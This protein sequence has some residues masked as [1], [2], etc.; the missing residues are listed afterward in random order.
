MEPDWDGLFFVLTLFHKIVTLHLH[1]G[2]VFFFLVLIFDALIPLCFSCSKP[3]LMDLPPGRTPEDAEV[4]AWRPGMTFSD[5][6]EA[7]F[8]VYYGKKWIDEI[9]TLYLK[10]FYFNS[11]ELRN[12]ILQDEIMES[13]SNLNS[14]GRFFFFF[15]FMIFAQTKLY[16]CDYYL[17]YGHSQINLSTFPSSFTLISVSDDLWRRHCCP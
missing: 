9:E 15:F 7:T 17:V 4:G 11:I 8:D 12:V 3:V 14:S 6:G 16:S 10:R 13:I 1:L 5:F 2:L